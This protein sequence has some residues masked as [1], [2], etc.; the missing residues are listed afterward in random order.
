MLN[1]SNHNGI[2]SCKKCG[3]SGHLTFQCRNFLQVD[4]DQS[5]VLD[6]SSTSTDSDDDYVTP[7]KKLREEEVIET[8]KKL[9][10][11]KKKQKKSKTSDSQDEKVKFTKAKKSKKSKSRKRYSSSSSST[12]SDSDSSHSSQDRSKKRRHKDKIREKKIHKTKKKNS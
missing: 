8:T 7:L 11:K 5:V 12:D 6:V 3:Y 9:K 1:N 2:K 10:K 4:P